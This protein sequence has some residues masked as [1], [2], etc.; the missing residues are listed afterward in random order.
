MCQRGFAGTN[1][2]FYGYKVV[3]HV[4]RFKNSGFL[5]DVGGENVYGGK[6]L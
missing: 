3:L 2:P 5:V 1:V 4:G 6:G